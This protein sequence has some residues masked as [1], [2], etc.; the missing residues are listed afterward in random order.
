MKKILILIFLLPL[1]AMA[2]VQPFCGSYTTSGP[3]TLN[4][5]TNHV[6][7]GLNIVGVPGQAVVTMNNCSHIEFVNCI[8]NGKMTAQQDANVVG[9]EMNS[10][11]DIMVHQNLITAVASGVYEV[12]CTGKIKVDSNKFLNMTGPSPRG[13][14]IQWNQ[15]NGPGFAFAYNDCQNVSGSSYPEDGVNVYMTN[16]TGPSPVWIYGNRILGGGPSTSGGGIILGDNGG[17]HQHAENNILVDPGQYGIS[18]AS[19]TFVALIGNK[20]FGR[21]QSFTNIGMYIWNQYSSSCSNDT[22]SNNQIKFTNSAGQENDYWNAQN[23]GTVVGESTNIAPAKIDAT[24]IPLP[25]FTTCSTSPTAP[26][27]TYSPSTYTF[28]SGKSVGT[29][30]PTN[31]GGTGTFSVNPALPGGLAI[32]ANSGQISGTPLGSSANT[33]YVVKC[34][35]TG[36]SGTFTLHITVN[37]AAPIINYAPNSFSFTVGT[38]FTPINPGSSAGIV[39][40]W[41]MLPL[42]PPGISFNPSNGQITGTPTATSVST[43]YTV[44]GTNTSGSSTAGITILVKA[45]AIPAPSITYPVSSIVWYQNQGI[46]PI[47]PTNTG[48]PVVSYAVTS[49]TLP[50]GISLNPATGIIQGTP[51]IVSASAVSIGITATNA[52][53]SSSFTISMAVN[54]GPA[55]HFVIIDNKILIL[56]Y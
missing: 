46:T 14:Y 41:S 11:H 56:N 9:F 30:I 33:S 21:Q 51:V 6:Y 8:I 37:I 53:G 28:T 38:P 19:G 23:C 29:I 16:G 44:T 34:T 7:S 3:L 47:N 2:Q 5:V 18:V 24:I 32:D 52:T 35:N 15:C 39:A 40:S 54:P 27:I 25:M 36:G 42:P 20:V 17:S 12:T 22:I 48:G 4:N 10:C 1:M 45:V 55:S 50:A 26:V 43:P 13:Q 49:G 31:T